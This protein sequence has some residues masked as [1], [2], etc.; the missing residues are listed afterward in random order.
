MLDFLKRGDLLLWEAVEVVSV[1]FVTNV[2]KGRGGEEKGR[3]G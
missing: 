3:G 1:H 2:G